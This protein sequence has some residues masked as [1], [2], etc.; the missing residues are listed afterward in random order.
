M[1]LLPPP[2]AYHER[3][4]IELLVKDLNKH[5]ATQDYAVVQGRSKIS[6]RGVR[7]KHW[8]RCDRSRISK[9]EG[10]GHRK[11]SSRRTECLFEAIATLEN[12]HGL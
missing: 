9:E 8:I 11:T 3:T 4:S 5:A 6:K 2:D 12:K 10:H 7:M 1:E